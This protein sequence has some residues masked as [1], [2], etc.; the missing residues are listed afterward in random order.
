MIEMNYI[1]ANFSEINN[2][3]EGTDQPIAS[4][5]YWT[6]TSVCRV[7][8]WNSDNHKLRD[9]Y[10]IQTID[11]SPIGL[12]FNNRNRFF[13]DNLGLT[14]NEAFDL[15]HQICNG[16]GMSY[17]DLGDAG[18]QVTVRRDQKIARFRPVRR[19]PL[20]YGTAD[21]DIEDLYNNYE[22]AK[23]KSCQGYDGE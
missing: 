5:K 6:S 15:S 14:E 20:V 18:K 19:I 2:G 3:I 21:I 17:Q 16:M 11:E 7:V 10:Q 4:D 1:A 13:R 9:L 23:C 22:F 8:G 12:G